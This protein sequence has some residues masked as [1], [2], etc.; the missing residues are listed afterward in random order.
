LTWRGGLQEITLYV[1][2]Y[3]CAGRRYGTS[4]VK[5]WKRLVVGFSKINFELALK[6][7]RYA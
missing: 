1:Q 2:K 3:E 5:V 7:I 6:I 4:V